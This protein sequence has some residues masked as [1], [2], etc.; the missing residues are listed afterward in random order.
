MGLPTPVN[1]KMIMSTP[2]LVFQI[3]DHAFA[4]PVQIVRQIVRA[5]AVTFVPNGPPLLSGLINLHGNIIPVF[6][7]R[8]QLNLPA[9]GIR[10]HDRII[11]V[12]IDNRP[13]CFIADAIADIIVPDPETSADAAAVYPQMA[14]YL[15]GIVKSH[16][17]TVLLYDTE[18]LFPA[19]VIRA[20]DDRIKQIGDIAEI[21]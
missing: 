19:G 9:C 12:E 15:I 7:I 21:S 13:V 17:H 2:H 3:E 18:T 8:K 6:D 14:D 11:V 16:G 4:I 5:V 1:E 20:M 10:L